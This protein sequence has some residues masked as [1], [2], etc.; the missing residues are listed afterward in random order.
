APSRIRTDAYTGVYGAQGRDY[1]VSNQE[2]GRVVFEST[3]PLSITEGMTIVTGFPRGEVVLGTPQSR[4]RWW[5]ADNG[6]W[7]ISLLLLGGAFL[8]YL[9][10]WFLVGRDPRVGLILREETPL[11][12]LSPASLRY[13]WKMGSDSR[14]LS[15]VMLQLAQK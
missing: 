14:I 11:I 6:F 8:H 2:L 1:T 10:L 9:V 15:V 7:V 13:I 12:G 3:R 4:M 5:I